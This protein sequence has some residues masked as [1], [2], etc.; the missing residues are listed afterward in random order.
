MKV[1]PRRVRWGVLAEPI[2]SES[3]DSDAAQESDLLAS[4]KLRVYLRDSN[5]GGNAVV[6]AGPDGVA[7]L[8][9]VVGEWAEE[10][11]VEGRLL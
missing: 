1:C 2:T 6:N 8:L 3:C 9:R 11:T 4:S 5:G 10:M 7:V